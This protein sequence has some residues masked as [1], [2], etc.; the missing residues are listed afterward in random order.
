MAKRCGT[1][2]KP[3]SYP[4]ASFWRQSMGVDF[5]NGSGVSYFSKVETLLDRAVALGYS[6]P[7]S[8]IL[9]ELSNFYEDTDDVLSLLDIAYMGGNGGSQ[10]FSFLN[11]INPSLYEIDAPAGITYGTTGWLPNGTTQYL[12]TNW[13]PATNGVN[14]TLN[15]AS[16][17]AWVRVLPATVLVIDGTITTG[18]RNTMRSQ[19]SSTLQK[20]NQGSGALAG[21]LDFTGTDYV[22]INRS[23]ANAIQGYKALVKT[24]TTAAAISVISEEQ[25]IFKNGTA[26]GDPRLLFY[27]CGGSLTEVQHNKLRNNLFTYFTNIG[28]L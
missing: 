22:A 26:F 24:E 18:S 25:T 12:S 13:N 1:V 3:C 16:R 21:A 8:T 5:I 6:V 4:R 15:A 9:A 17:G 27:F 28:A 19:S 20:I 11:I 2:N 10:A 14:Y 23:D 7:N